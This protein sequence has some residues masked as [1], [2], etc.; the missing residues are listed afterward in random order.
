ML[1]QE[2]VSIVYLILTEFCVILP[3]NDSI[4]YSIILVL[5]LVQVRLSAASFSEAAVYFLAVSC[6]QSIQKLK[7]RTEVSNCPLLRVF[8]TLKSNYCLSENFS[9]WFRHR[10]KVIDL[11]LILS[12]LK[13]NYHLLVLL[14]NISEGVLLCV[15]TREVDIY[16]Y[17]YFTI[18]YMSSQ[19]CL[20]FS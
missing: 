3:I 19:I 9:C 17:L 10:A 11:T 8:N 20:H 5:L 7:Y 4:M 18:S 15:C 13:S 2:I 14:L 12:E 1:V 6:A 16:I